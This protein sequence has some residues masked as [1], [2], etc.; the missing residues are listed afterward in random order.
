[1]SSFYVGA[2]EKKYEPL[3]LEGGILSFWEKQEIYRRAKEL[4]RAGPK[5]Y[6][7]DGPPYVTNVPHAGTAWNKILKDIVIRIKRMQRYNVSDQPGYDCHGLPIEVQVEEQL[8]V[9]S[10][11]DIEQKIGIERFIEACKRYAE[12][13]IEAQTRVFK[14][15]GIW[16]DWEKPYIT[17]DNYYVESVWWTIK[18]AYDK[19]LLKQGLLVVH[20][21]SRCETALAGY[22]VTDEYREVTDYSIFVKFRTRE[23]PKESI[24]I[25]TT[26]PWTLP[27]NMAVLVHPKEIYVK[28][29]S[30]DEVF[31]LAKSRVGE[32]FGNKKYSI[33]EEFPG[34]NLAGNKYSAP[35]DMESPELAKVGNAHFVIA[36]EKYVSMEEGTGCVHAAPGH[37]EEDF[38]VCTQHN[39]PVFSPIDDS[40]KFTEEAGKY[41]G[42]STVEASKLIIEDLRSKG[43]LFDESR[44]QHLY[45]HCWRCKTPLLLRATDQWFLTVTS[46]KEKMLAENEKVK[47]VPE[48]AGSKRFRDWLEGARDWVISRQRYW[49][50]PLP[51]W[52][53]QSCGNRECIGSLEELV[54]RA[55]LHSD[56]IDLHRHFVDKVTFNCRSCGG[57]MKRVQDIIDVWLDSGV[58]SWAS[59]GYP[60]HRTEFERLWPTDMIIEA[61]DQTRGWFYSQLG[62]GIVAFDRV[63]YKTVLMH[64]HVLDATGQKFSKSLGN[65]VAPQ[66]AIAK[67]GRDA[68]RLYLVGNTLWEDPRFSWERLEDVAGNLQTIWN[69]YVFASTYMNLDKFSPANWP[70]ERLRENMEPEDLWVMSRT[71]NTVKAV[72]AAYDSYQPHLAVKALVDFYIEDLSHGYVRFVRKRTWLEEDKSEKLAAYSTLYYALK[73]VLV[74]LAPVTPFIAEQ[75]FLAMFRRAEPSSPESIHLMGL[76]EV[77]ESWIDEGLEKKMRTVQEIVSS[78]L[79]AR[80]KAK[81]KLRQPMR[82]M[83][84]LTDSETALGAVK[85]L[86]SLILEQANTKKLQI[87][88]VRKRETFMELVLRPDLGRLGPRLREKMDGV[89][90]RI[91]ESDATQVKKAFDER[92]EHE[93]FFEGARI[94]IEPE[95]V[96]FEFSPKRNYYEAEFGGGYVLINA[97]TTR[98]EQAEGLA[99]DVVRRVQ[100]MRKEMLLDVDAYIDCVLVVPDQE[101]EELLDSERDFI[102]KEIRASSLRLT[103]HPEETVGSAK[104]K[105]WQI[106]DARLVIGVTKK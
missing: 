21:C 52:V 79:A 105:D 80:M 67:H 84:V 12:T 61:H 83:V 101:T 7:L 19:G 15:L 69:T 41:H 18:K 9:E 2:L 20:W 65:F 29:R 43:L 49:G 70:P 22:E 60:S 90:K 10:K 48:W 71:Q 34:E 51:I 39:I 100:M 5:Y 96:K 8:N 47:W 35:L 53:C 26:T 11:K 98:E 13:N 91:T 95:D 63:P 66:D 106:G 92:G 32:V 73:T 82:E 68:L 45:P 46:F 36:N 99:R 86:E 88:P 28:A 58:A 38:E 54:S 55:K 78:S 89:V 17:F 6:F 104:V 103:L 87:L 23:D 30:G 72:L 27:S 77:K 44:I 33:L 74:L 81:M 93:V 94:L 24:L 85:H 14:D 75:L 1:M 62:A 37:G 25:W 16:M 76:P 102:L 57:T 59:I 56:H 64:G 50:V 97:E 3:S 40:G 42:L 31:V 4:C